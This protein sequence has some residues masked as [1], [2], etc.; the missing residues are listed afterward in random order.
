M[1]HSDSNGFQRN[2]E[3]DMRDHIS[4]N[5]DK[6]SFNRQDVVLGVDETSSKAY[7]SIKN[8]VVAA[9]S[10]TICVDMI[11]RKPSGNG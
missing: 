4:D 11:G 7:N 5:S 9:E 2:V 8:D 10:G 6:S 3:R 1:G